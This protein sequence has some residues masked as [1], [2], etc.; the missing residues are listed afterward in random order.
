MIWEYN[1][2]LN[3]YSVVVFFFNFN[4]PIF[5]AMVTSSRYYLPISF[6]I[7]WYFPLN[8][9]IKHTPKCQIIRTSCLWLIKNAKNMIFRDRLTP[10]TFNRFWAPLGAPP[11]IYNC[12]Y[13]LITIVQCR[14]DFSKQIW[15]NLFYYVRELWLFS[16]NFLIFAPVVPLK[17]LNQTPIGA[18]DNIFL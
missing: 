1:V 16:N 2:F 7:S 3:Y 15:Y 14:H 4:G 6:S 13:S 10:P 9:L 17:W 11:E 18:S 8:A 12:F 5:V